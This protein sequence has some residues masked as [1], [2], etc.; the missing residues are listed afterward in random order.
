MHGKDLHPGAG[1]KADGVAQRNFRVLVVNPDAAFHRH[2][3]RDGGAH[4][5]HAFGH[6]LR[7]AHQAGAEAA[8]LHAVRWAADIQVDFAIAEIGAD[9]RGLRQLYGIA[10]AQLQRHGA[11]AGIETQKPLALAMQDRVRCH[12]LRVKKC[13]RAELTMEK[14]AMPV[15]PVHHGRD[16]EFVI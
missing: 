5:R 10:A 15:R 8:R 7:L 12:H 3:K 6:K 13:A 14:P 16:G 9:L 11:L 4:R 2:R 1:A